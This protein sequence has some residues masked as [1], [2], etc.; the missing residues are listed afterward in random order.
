[1]PA[2][3]GEGAVR[4]GSGRQGVS[5]SKQY[6]LMCHG[7]AGCC[8]LTACV[9]PSGPPNVCQPTADE[10][11]ACKLVVRLPRQTRRLVTLG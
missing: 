9:R 6:L 11:A 1:M 5:A 4:Q 3:T 7:T 2:A 10:L 8:G